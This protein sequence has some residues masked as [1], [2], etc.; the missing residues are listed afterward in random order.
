MRSVQLEKAFAAAVDLDLVSKKRLTKLR[1]VKILMLTENERKAALRGFKSAVLL[2]RALCSEIRLQRQLVDMS[3]GLAALLADRYDEAA[4]QSA[5][6]PQPD[7]IYID[8]EDNHDHDHYHMEREQEQEKH[9]LRSVQSQKLKPTLYAKGNVGRNWTELIKQ[10]FTRNA[11]IIVDGGLGYQPRRVT[12][13]AKMD[14]GC[15][16]NLITLEVFEKFGM[17][18]S[19]LVEIPEEDQFDL[20]MLEGARCHI[21]YKVHLTWYYDGDM[22]MRHSDFFVVK[23]GPF[24]MLIGSDRLAQEFAEHG[25]PG[26]VVGKKNKKKADRQKEIDDHAKHLKEQ[27]TLELEERKAQQ[28]KAKVSPPALAKKGKKFLSFFRRRK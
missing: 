2:L 20:V 18:K 19:I 6:A 14:T 8:S 3:A 15:N 26:L 5:E 11:T 21:L 22:K 4:S 25:R 1:N 17:D 7:H 27:E 23:T 10:N 9:G 13:R 28:A 16:D 12:V 24:D